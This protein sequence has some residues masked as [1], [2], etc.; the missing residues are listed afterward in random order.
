MNFDLIRF[1]DELRE[2]GTLIKTL[3]NDTRA[4]AVALFDKNGEIFSTAGEVENLD[5]T[6]FSDHISSSVAATD[7]L[8]KLKQGEDISSLHGDD[9]Y[10]IYVS[11]VDGKAIL[12]VLFDSKSSEGLVKLRVRNTKGK[13]APIFDN[14]GAALED[15]TADDIDNLFS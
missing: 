4:T 15:I 11:L 10:H 14:M 7:D 1:E 12:L 8:S 5:A 13:L 2:I 9:G 6:I 3:H